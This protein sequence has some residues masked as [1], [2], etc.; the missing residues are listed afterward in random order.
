M[1][2]N[3]VL[4][5]NILFA[6]LIKSGI[7]AKLIFS[8][9]FQLFAPEFLFQE[10]HKYKPLIMKKTYRTSEEFEQYY[11]IVKN[12]I[13]I[14]SKSRIITYI[15]HASE[16]TPYSKDTVYLALAMMLKCCVWSNDKYL[17]EK[18]SEVQILT[19]K[20]IIDIGNEEY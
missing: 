12:R 15:S 9:K 16:L 11:S 4:D 20:E 17:R 6:S 10:F 13:T 18:Q 19:T 2:T 3:L 14:I 5:A 1:K 7:T 8:D